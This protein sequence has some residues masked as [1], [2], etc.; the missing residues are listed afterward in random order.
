MADQPPVRQQWASSQT[1]GVTSATLTLPGAVAAGDF[2]VLAVAVSTGFSSISDNVNGSWSAASSQTFTGG[3]L[4]VYFFKNSAAAAANGLTITVSLTSSGDAVIWAAEYSNVATVLGPLQGHAQTNGN[5]STAT[6]SG[7]AAEAFSGGDLCIAAVAAING[8]SATCDSKWTLLGNF[9]TNGQIT[10]AV[11]DRHQGE[12][13][14]TNPVVTFTLPSSQNWAV[15]EDSWN[16]PP[17]QLYGTATASTTLTT[18]NTL[19]PSSGT[20]ASSIQN[21]VAKN[22][23]WLELWSQ[24]SNA[25]FSGSEPAASGHGW[26]YDTTAL[27]GLD[28]LAVGGASPPWN[29]QVSIT[30]S[31]STSSFVADVHARWYKRS[32]GGV[33]TLIADGF[34][35]SV[36]VTTTQSQTSVPMTFSSHASF[37]AGD[38]LYMDI[39]LNVTTA[40]G[41]TTCKC[42]LQR[43]TTWINVVAPGLVNPI[44]PLK[45]SAGIMIQSPLGGRPRR[46]AGPWAVLVDMQSTYPGGGGGSSSPQREPAS[47]WYPALRGRRQHRRAPDNAGTLFQDRVISSTKDRLSIGRVRQHY[48]RWWQ[49]VSEILFA[50]PNPLKNP[51]AWLVM[52]MRGSRPRRRLGQPPVRMLDATSRT[53]SAPPLPPQV[54]PASVW[55]RPWQRRNSR[56]RTSDTGSATTFQDV[57]IARAVERTW[58]GRVR[59]SFIRWLEQWAPGLDFPPNPLKNPAGYMV[60]AGKRAIRRRGSWSGAVDQASAINAFPP[61]PP[62]VEPAS[63]WLTASRER[64]RRGTGIRTFDQTQRTYQDNVIS[65]AEDRGVSG[66]VRQHFTRWVQGVAVGLFAPPNPLKNPVS[67][68]VAVG[69]RVARRW[70]WTAPLDQANAINTQPPAPPQ[71]EPSGVWLTASHE[72]RRRGQAIRTFDHTQRTFQDSVLSSAQDRGSAGRVRQSFTRWV[73]GVAMGLFAPPN[74]LKNSVSY[75]VEGFRGKLRRR[76]SDQASAISSFPPAPPQIEPASAFVLSTKERRRRGAAVRT[77]DSTQTSYQD[78]LLARSQDRGF[79]GR[80][81]RQNFWLASVLVGIAPLK[82]AASWMVQV[83]RGGR[84]LRRRA[85]LWHGSADSASAQLVTPPAS[86]RVEPASVWIQQRRGARRRLP[87][88]TGADQASIIGTTPVISMARERTF[89]ARTRR[90]WNDLWQSLIRWFIPPKPGSV[91]A[92][93]TLAASVSPFDALAGTVAAANALAASVSPFDALAGSVAAADVAAGTVSAQDFD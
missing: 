11:A 10:L 63:N 64:R 21:T 28:L 75:M 74:P 70:P 77:S 31:T 9:G 83:A 36:T 71:R 40:S 33:F 8:I 46:R 12:D 55:T 44:S 50:P 16:L 60:A 76:A 34:V 52:A 62:Q 6:V 29:G 13:A 39:V 58:L 35:G 38:K 73:Q 30:L 53:L 85:G 65:S 68:M 82:N 86:P 84:G 32:S 92:V 43:G 51:V 15:A 14:D 45:N 25:T 87:P 66:R 3:Q 5:S 26:L 49:G 56:T 91:A 1:N 37:A 7:G 61:A 93:D 27:E 22:T 17:T 41:S 78:S 59:Q 81:R 57:V 4:G 20:T 90:F 24:G 48:S 79:I 69:R 67:Y 88:R 72:R 18:A 42:T 54:E 47:V 2:L 23:G 19:D 89:V 80:L